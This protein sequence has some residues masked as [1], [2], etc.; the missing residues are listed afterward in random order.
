[1]V[2]LCTYECRLVPGLLQ[3][4]PYVR[5]VFEG[6]IPLV[7]D[8]Q[9]EVLV[10]ARLERQTMLRERPTVPF[11]FIVEEHVF[12]RRFGDVERIRELL[13]YVLE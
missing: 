11:G 4:E 9:V 2:S 8:E 13:D 7:P 1:M 6:T 5:A 10:A 3:S 12:R